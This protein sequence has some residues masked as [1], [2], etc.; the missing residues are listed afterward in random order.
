[1]RAAYH[2]VPL[3]QSTKWRLREIA[4]RAMPSL[5][6]GPAAPGAG[7][8]AAPAPVAAGIRDAGREAALERAIRDVA[9]RVPAGRTC[10]HVIVLPFLATGG[11][12][13]TALN[14]ARAV[15][16]SVADGFTLLAIAD[17]GGTADALPMPPGVVPLVLESTLGRSDYPSKKLLLEDLIRALRP[18]VVHNI[19]SEVAWQLIIERG[20]ALRD[21]TRLFASIFA[22]QFTERGDRIGYAAYFL[23]KGLPQ[24]H[25]LLSDNRRFVDDAI[26]YYGIGADRAK[27]RAIYNPS[28]AW[29]PEVE[30]KARVGLDALPGRVRAAG[31][32]RVLWAGRLDR[33]KRPELLYELARTCDFADFDVFGQVVVDAGLPMPKLPNLRYVGPFS[34]PEALFDRAE[35]YDAFVFTSRWEGMP[36][37]L[38]EAGSWG[39]PIV[40]PTVGGVGELVSDATGYPLPEQ[41]SAEDYLAALA[42]IRSDPDEAA[43]RAVRMLDLIAARH[44]WRAFRKAVDAIPGYL[45]ADDLATGSSAR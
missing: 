45:R 8:S 9:A 28:R 2:R 29:S 34:S 25:G 37:V 22:F 12:E 19:N 7:A 15:G 39:T 11:A 42:A 20:A 33:E 3:K 27:M 23:E 6:F 10:S 1:M 36:N 40:A 14:Y 26:A 41:P 4:F 32:L 21:L 17:R 43:R 16:E 44:D 13:L 30:R 18:E 5:F 24:L 35:R 38:L 31:R